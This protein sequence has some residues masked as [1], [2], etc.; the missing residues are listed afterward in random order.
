MSGAAPPLEIRDLRVA[1]PVGAGGVVR[2]VNGIN[3]TLERGQSLGV[4]GESGCGKS[5]AFSCVMRLLKTPP[6]IVGGEI[7]LDGEDITTLPERKMREIRGKKVSMIFQEPMRSLNPVMRVG[8]Q[9]AETLVLH[10][11][12]TR[13]QAA[14]RALELMRLAEIPDAESRLYAYPH[15][16]SGGLRQRVMIAIALACNPRILIADEPTTALDATI[17]AQILDL[18]KRL[19][20]ETGMSIVMI[21][22]DMGVVADIVDKVAV[23]YAGS[24]VE[25]ADTRSIFTDPMHPYTR[26]LIACI[27][28]MGASGGR[29]PVIDGG[30]P[31]PARLPDGCAFHP[32]CR[33]ADGICRCVKPALLERSPGRFCACH[34]AWDDG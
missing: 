34:A 19:R 6:A 28:A 4:V 31:D 24:I 8:A 21:T 32:R 7:L 10:E 20:R 12:M 2:A 29:M 17:Q 18:L 1:F 27:P 3:L 14:G 33:F 11:R 16:L 25:T 9:I 13:R 22:H 23:F 30:P 5:V 26:G 15:Q